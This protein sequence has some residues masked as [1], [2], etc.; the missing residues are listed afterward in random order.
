MTQV[1]K[2]QIETFY[3]AN[4]AA[5]DGLAAY[6][7]VP[8]LWLVAA[9]QL[10]SSLNPTAKNSIGAVGLNQMLPSTLAPYG[11]TPEQY[12]TGGV[13]Y[14]LK[15][16]ERFFAPIRGKVKRAGDLYLFNLYP[17][18]VIQNWPMDAVIGK[19]EDFTIRY[20][21][22]LNKIYDGNAGLDFNKD[23]TLTRK[24]VVDF[25]ENRYDEV[26]KTENGSFFFRDLSIDFKTH[27]APWLFVACVIAVMIYV[28]IK[29]KT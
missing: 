15:I 7:S 19:D 25:F 9:F 26:L 22:S 10:E 2:Q 13:A 23:K 3:A 18:A 6:L 16:M 21:T 4:K 17:V 8:P 29:T 5:V 12:R 14:Q 28:L 20:G 1:T 24:D 11:I 27:W